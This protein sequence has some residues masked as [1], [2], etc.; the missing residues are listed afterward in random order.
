MKKIYQFI[1]NN[2]LFKEISANDFE[3]MLR[4]VEGR[5]KEYEKGA[6]IQLAGNP[7]KTLGLVVSGIVQVIRED[8]NGKQ[9]LMAELGKGELFGEVFACAGVSHSPVTVRSGENCEVLHL[10]YRKVITACSSGCPFH[11]KLTENMLTLVAE[12]NLHLMQKIDILSKRTTR[13]RLLLFFDYHRKGAQKF[14]VPFSRE[15]LAAYLCVE[16][17]AMSAELSKMQREGLIHYDRNHFEMEE[18]P[19]K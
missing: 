10:N 11:Q 2:P 18:L 9:N 15:E 4:C 8:G 5:V 7:V 16:R 3:T 17:S 6:V 13:E 12:K 1:K 19:R 14:T